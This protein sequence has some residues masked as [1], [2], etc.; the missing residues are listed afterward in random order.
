M[1]LPSALRV[2]RPSASWLPS[3]IRVFR[4]SCTVRVPRIAKI[5][6]IPEISTSRNF[7]KRNRRRRRKRNLNLRLFHSGTTTPVNIPMTLIPKV[8]TKTN[9]MI[10]ANDL[11]SN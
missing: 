4:L 10:S 7:T 9:P 11:S 5:L 8:N 6:R 1:R 2:L 3:I